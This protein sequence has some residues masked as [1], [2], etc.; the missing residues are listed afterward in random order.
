MVSLQDMRIGARYYDNGGG[1]TGYFT[2]DI[3]E[4]IV[5]DSLLSDTAR[6]S[7][8][9][10][11]LNKYNLPGAAAAPEPGALALILGGGTPLI[12]IVS[13]RRRSR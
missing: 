8:E 11:L 10:S 6:Q 4:V 2:G 1:E 3:S 13:R 5:Y 12:G 7:V 9:Q